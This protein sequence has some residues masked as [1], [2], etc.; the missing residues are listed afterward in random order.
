[1]FVG[2]SLA[3]RTVQVG[4]RDGNMAT[5]RDELGSILLKYPYL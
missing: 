5:I 4:W 1:M 2:M 3:D